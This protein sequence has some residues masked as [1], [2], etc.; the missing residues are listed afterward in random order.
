MTDTN[1]KVALNLMI[2]SCVQGKAR[3]E[4]YLEVGPTP[5]S[6]T[7]HGVPQLP[8][9]ISG[10]TVDKVFFDHGI[11][12]SVLERLHGLVESPNAVFKSATHAAQG[13]VVI[14]VE[15]K[16]LAPVIIAVHANKQIGRGKNVNEIASVYAKEDLTIQQRWVAEGLLLWKK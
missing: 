8:L 3:H 15:L 4:L 14:T 7:M 12:K 9:A 1:Y 16:G 10:K 2:Q 5:T 6:L 13:Y 11:T